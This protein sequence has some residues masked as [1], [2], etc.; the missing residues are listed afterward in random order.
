MRIGILGGTFNPPHMGHIN[1]AL[2]AMKGIPLDKVIFIPTGKPPHKELAEGS[3]TTAQRLEMT[4]LAAESIGAEVSDIEILREGKSY[5]VDTL[6]ELKKQ[7][8]EDELWLIMGTDMFLSLETWREPETIFSLAKTAVIPRD[9]DDIGKLSDFGEHLRK[10]YGAEFRVLDTE[11]I[12]ISSTE[13][14]EELNCGEA[15]EFLP[16]QVYNYIVENQ[17]YG[18]SGSDGF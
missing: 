6:K 11:V 16:G 18:V 14:R 5:T 12:E 4:R 9:N 7:F 8:P 15:I 13:L 3:A 17:L 1:A 10:K 2:S